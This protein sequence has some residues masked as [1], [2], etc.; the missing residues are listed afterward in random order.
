MTVSPAR[1]V[2]ILLQLFLWT[3]LLLYPIFRFVDIPLGDWLR[4][5]HLFAWILGTLAAWIAW[6]RLFCGGFSK[7]NTHHAKGDGDSIQN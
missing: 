5:M 1:A 3:L 2:D 7:L 6:K 4:R